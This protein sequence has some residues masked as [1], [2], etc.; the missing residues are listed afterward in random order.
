MHALDVLAEPV[1][2][3]ADL[4]RKALDHAVDNGIDWDFG[5]VYVEGPASGGV[6]DTAKEFWQNA[7]ALIALLDATRLFGPEKYWPAYLN[8]H[9]FV[10]EKLI[11]HDPGEWWPLLTRQGEPVWTHMS[12]SWKVNYHTVRAMVQSVKRLT[13]V[14]ESL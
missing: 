6:Y 11:K 12:H 14:L 9:R 8:V 2:P 1:E 7:E 4:I 10:M 3:H 13:R 5:G